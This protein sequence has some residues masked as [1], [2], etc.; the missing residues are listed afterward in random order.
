MERIV[1]K[2]SDWVYGGS[3]RQVGEWG[4]MQ[5]QNWLLMHGIDILH[6]N[7]RSG[8]KEIDIIA[9]HRDELVFI[10]VKCRSTSIFAPPESAVNGKKWKNIGSAATDYMIKNKYF[11]K[12]RFDVLAV[13]NTPH[14][15]QIMHFMDAFH[16]SKTTLS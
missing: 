5:A 9:K 8:H 6:C 12:F 3:K 7:W 13:T 16:R 2:E 4:E 10:E 1:N 14:G 11:G 15:K